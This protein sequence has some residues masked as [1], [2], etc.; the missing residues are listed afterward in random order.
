MT[1][2]IFFFSVV[3]QDP[4]DSLSCEFYS[5]CGLLKNGSAICEC[6]Q[7]CTLDWAPVCGSDNKTY[8]NLCAMQVESCEKKVM[9]RKQSDGECGKIRHKLKFLKRTRDGLLKAVFLFNK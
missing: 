2:F 9:I 1:S 7:Y 4:C 5:T 6:P 3:V 8:P